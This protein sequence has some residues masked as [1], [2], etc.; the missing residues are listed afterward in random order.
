MYNLTTVVVSLV[1]RE[2]NITNFPI[3][4]II[5]SLYEHYGINQGAS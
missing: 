4:L 1:T 5:P 2:E 3:A